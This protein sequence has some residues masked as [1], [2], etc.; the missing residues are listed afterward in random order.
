MEDKIRDILF[1]IG[2][3]IKI[4]KINS[5]DMIIE[6][7]YEKYVQELSAIIREEISKQT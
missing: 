1:S 2:K 7:D 3:D 4:H 5:V 6:I